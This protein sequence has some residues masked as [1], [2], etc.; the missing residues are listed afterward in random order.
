MKFSRLFYIPMAAVFILV[1]SSAAYFMGRKTLSDSLRMA[2]ENS[3]LTEVPSRISDTPG[4][5]LGT[6]PKEIGSSVSAGLKVSIVP[7]SSLTVTLSPSVSATSAAK[8]NLNS[9]TNKLILLPSPTTADT[10]KLKIPPVKAG[11]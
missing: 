8:L 9:K 6:S 4:R 1:I 10:V 7:K 5:G 3:A 11:L 2:V